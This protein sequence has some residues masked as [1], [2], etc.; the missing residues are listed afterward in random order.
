MNQ[1]T[2]FKPY[3]GKEP[4]IFVSYSHKDSA[5]VFPV[6]Q[7]LHNRGLRIW[8]DK[9]IDPGSEWPEEIANHL[10]NC[11]LFLLFMSPDAADSHNVRREITM[12]VDKKK[13]L[14]NVYLKETELQPGLQLQLNLVQYI[15]Y[16][17]GNENFGDFIN[18]LTEILL[19]KAPGIQGRSAV[20]K[21]PH[22]NQQ[23]NQPMPPPKREAAVSP[24]ASHKL[25]ILVGVGIV[26]AV[27]VLVVIFAL[28]TPD[29]PDVGD[30]GD[31]GPE[32]ASVPIE[33]P[34]ENLSD[35]AVLIIA[36]VAVLIIG[37]LAVAVLRQNKPVPQTH[38]YAPAAPPKPVSFV[39]TDRRP[40]AHAPAVNLQGIRGT[41]GRF[42]KMALPINGRATLGRDPAQC[43][44]LFP[45][46][47]KGVSSLHCEITRIG[48]GLQIIDRGSRYGTFI[49]GA[50][51]RPNVPLNL[52]AGDNFFLGDKHNSFVAY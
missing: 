34:V 1:D 26:F 20:V 50:K 41:G 18:R 4:Y 42:N 28:R 44:I 25:P 52:K 35:D 17:S 2:S 29:L 11:G 38:T 22:I 40:A 15:S 32:S 9:G 16:V 46:Q 47:T 33:T 6:L 51:M 5:L 31:G 12:A 21:T 19:R 43:S 7:E 45:E 36:A 39:G 27:I 13:P 3:E 23:I 48:N 24:Q 49:N 14:L 30:G 37:A 10:L 8:Y